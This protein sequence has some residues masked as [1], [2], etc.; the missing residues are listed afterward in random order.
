MTSRGGRGGR[1]TLRP[2]N[3]NVEGLLTVLGQYLY[4]SPHAALR[5]LVQNA[6][7]SIVRRR[8]EDPGFA[9]GS[10]HVGV[11]PG[12]RE[13]FV[14]DD[15][16][17]LTEDEIHRYLAT[18]GSGYTRELRESSGSEDLIGLFGLGFVSAFVLAREVAVETTSHRD[19]SATHLYR[20]ADGQ[21]YTVSPMATAAPGTRVTVA[22]KNEHVDL[23][24]AAV[25]ERILGHYCALLE[26]PLTVGDAAD[27]VNAEPPPW[28]GDGR[29]EHPAFAYRRDLDFAMRM[30]RRFEPLAVMRVA[31][32]DGG[33]AH[34]LLWI[35]GGNSYATSDQRRV[36]VYVRGM[37]LDDDARE[38][39]PTWAGFVSGAIESRSLTPTANRED[40]HRDAGY[41]AVRAQLQATLVEGL[42]ALPDRQ[43]EAWRRV[44][45]RHNEAL[46]GA[47]LCDERLFTLLV[48]DVKLPTTDGDLTARDAVRAGGGR[49]HVA[50]DANDDMGLTLFRALRIP[51]A[52]GERFAVLSF[53]H[54]YC[55]AMRARLVEVGSEKGE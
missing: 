4:R 7:D 25:L 19:P 50:V 18:I 22:L 42:S 35:N 37:L 40:L 14:E 45:R 33:D 55:R 5:E 43:P 32:R 17:G 6:H 51:V 15:G 52:R 3:V 38:L 8:L 47:S 39:L 49:L 16:A 9:G 34:G 11:D 23:C 46:L 29:D 13:V 53:A 30:E 2:T 27:A 12:A 41:D 54:R 31:P 1:L 28:R 44:L 26:V 21:R 48:D 20:S 36:G 24:D 10:I